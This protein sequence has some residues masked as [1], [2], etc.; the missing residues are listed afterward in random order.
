M[1]KADSP[2]ANLLCLMLESVSRDS[3]EIQ[4]DAG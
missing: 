4:K 2:L 1:P 3:D